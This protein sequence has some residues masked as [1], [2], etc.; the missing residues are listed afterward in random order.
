MSRTITEYNGV[1]C[2]VDIAQVL[3]LTGETVTPDDMAKA[4][5]TLDVLTEVYPD[6]LP[7]DLMAG[8]KRRL[9]DMLCYQAPWLKG[10]VDYF[11]EVDTTQVSQDGVSATYASRYATKLAP[12]A[13]MCF[14]RLSWNRAGTQTKPTLRQFP[15]IDAVKAAVLSG[16]ATDPTGTTGGIGRAFT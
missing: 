11:A 2:W 4:Q 7:D 6:M 12:M 9:E 14:E 10:R 13:F 16:E 3:S 5:A 8:D 15:N 1:T